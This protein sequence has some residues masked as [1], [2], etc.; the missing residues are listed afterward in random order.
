M[1]KIVYIIIFSLIAVSCS[2]LLEENPKAVATTTFYNTADELESAVL[3]GYAPLKEGM[4]YLWYINAGEVDYAVGRLSFANMSDFDQPWNGTNIWRSSYIWENMYR[5]IRNVNIVISNAPDATEATP[6]EINKYIAE[7]KFL[8][9]F[10][11]FK[12]V[13][14]WGALPLRTEDNMSESDVPRS[15]VAD[16]Y[17]LILSDL[18]FAEANLPATQPQAGRADQ[19][20]AKSML[21]HIYLH[22]E[23]WSD[24]RSMA[25]EIINSGRYS[26]INI[27]TSDDY[28]KI[29]GPEV[30][31]TSEEIFYLKYNYESISYIGRYR[32]S[33]NSIY[34]PGGGV[35]AKLADSTDMKVIREW[36]MNDLR[37]DFMLY[38]ADIGFGPRTMLFKKFIATTLDNRGDNDYP[39]YRYSD[40]LLFYAEADCRVNNGPTAD[41]MEKLNMIHR[42]AYG[43]DVNASS[44]VDFNV[45]DYNKE[46]FIDLVLQEGM[47]EQMDEAKRYLELKRTGKLEEIVMENRGITVAESHLLFPIPN[48]EYDYNKAIDATTDQNPGY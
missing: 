42:R 17:N 43:F 20:A 41:G 22:L 31:T 3:G 26:L 13:Q 21:T 19:Y 11:Y 8:R 7:A 10:I 15:P 35:Y 12:M 46:S 16:V 39:A 24:A 5:A 18:E 9:A 25:L 27:T 36:D 48:T 30:V 1:N 23:R 29:F 6:D 28:Y 45:N 47:Y 2:D 37:R 40:I 4:N 44:P 14:N 33:G 38:N 32:H 34:Y